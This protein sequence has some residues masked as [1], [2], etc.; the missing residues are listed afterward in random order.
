MIVNRRWPGRIPGLDAIPE[1]ADPA[2]VLSAS[3]TEYYDREVRRR[4]DQLGSGVD[5][6]TGHV[7]DGTVKAW[8][9]GWLSAAERD[10]EGR[11]ETAEL[12]VDRARA[13]VEP[14]VMALR[15]DASEIEDATTALEE[16]RQRIRSLA[17]A[18]RRAREAG[19]L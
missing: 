16:A 17:P 14:L 9:C 7:L 11:R 1:W 6:G 15:T 3:F 10:Y 2:R 12:E 4:V 13:R 5:F 19:G 8:L 18:R